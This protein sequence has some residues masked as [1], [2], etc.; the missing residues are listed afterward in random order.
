MLPFENN[1]EK[2][3]AITLIGFPLT[4]VKMTVTE[5][6]KDTVKGVVSPGDEPRE[7]QPVPSQPYRLGRL[8]RLGQ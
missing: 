3:C 4:L 6:I 5:T 8:G 2:K 7:L 1:G